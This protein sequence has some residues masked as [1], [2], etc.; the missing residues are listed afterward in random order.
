ML[1]PNRHSSHT[2]EEKS[3]I[4]FKRNLPPEWNIT[5]PNRDY[6]MDL[7]VE[8]TENGV[9]RGL[10]VIVQLKA[11]KDS[12]VQS[13]FERQGLKIS[14]YNYLWGNLRVAML[15][16]YIEAEDEAYWI[17]LKDIESPNQGNKTF[18]V[19][20]PR[21]QT[22]STIDWNLITDYVKEITDIKRAAAIAHTRELR[23]AANESSG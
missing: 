3:A 19:Y 21:T 16:K 2:L 8:I 18:T 4:F 23:R 5:S 14:T 7:S 10:E 12:N 22:L 20:L 13:D 15:I 17:L 9:Y 11:S 1:Y 6:G